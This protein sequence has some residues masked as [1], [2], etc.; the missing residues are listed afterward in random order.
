MKYSKLSKK[1]RFFFEG[2]YKSRLTGAG[3]W[4]FISSILAGAFG[5]VFQISMGR[6]LTIE[7]YGEFS[8]IFAIFAITA[9]PFGTL[10]MVIVR[11]VSEYRTLP[12]GGIEEISSF[13]IWTLKRGVIFGVILIFLG[14]LSAPIF[15][16]YV[17]SSNII[18]LYFLYGVLF[19]TLL[20]FI[21]NAFIQGLQNFKSLGLSNILLFLFRVAISSLLVWLGF[22][23][24]GAIGGVLVAALVTWL[25]TFGAVSSLFTVTKKPQGNHLRLGPTIPVLVANIAFAAMTQS[26]IIYVNYF[27]SPHD[28]SMYA[29]ASVLG[30]AILYLSGGIVLALFPMVAEKH[31]RRESDLTLL[32][33]CMG[34]V[35]SLSLLGCIFYYI[36][37]EMLIYFLFGTNYTEAGQLL[38]YY[39]IAMLPMGIVMI[40]E[41]YF[42]A[43]NRIFFSY[44]FILIV[45]LQFLT[46]MHFHESL[47]TVILLVGISGFLAVLIG[48]FFLKRI[49]NKV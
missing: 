40:L 19:F 18:S 33:Q 39:G 34:L 30:K 23:V 17:K 22:G 28:A 35:I 43:K 8:A 12:T 2:I 46:L 14:V 7:E 1:I 32:Q 42:I 20:L 37:G 49:T 4:L 16:A 48:L 36:F 26:D 29:A 38:K 15:Q 45:P 44:L 24:H 31:A 27:Y 11:R 21:N 3:L 47:I 41:H 6:T 25:I 10:T 9:A 13:Y 5:Y